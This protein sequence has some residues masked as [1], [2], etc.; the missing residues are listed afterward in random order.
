MAGVNATETTETGNEV[1]Q[2]TLEFTSMDMR[3]KERG[4][5]RVE[6]RDVETTALSVDPGGKLDPID[7]EKGD[8][9]DGRPRQRNGRAFSM[10][11]ERKLRDSIDFIQ[12]HF[13]VFILL[14]VTSA[15]NL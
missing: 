12:L 9:D 2:P 14:Y 11:A 3:D 13:L 10:I 4:Q 15:G 8:A 5:R 6:S 7:C 1:S